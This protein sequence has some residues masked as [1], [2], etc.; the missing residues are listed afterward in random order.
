[1]RVRRTRRRCSRRTDERKDLCRHEQGAHHLKRRHR[2]ERQEAPWQH[3]PPRVH[4]RTAQ[5]AGAHIYNNVKAL[6]HVN[7]PG[8]ADA[9]ADDIARDAADLI[10][11]ARALASIVKGREVH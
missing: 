6:Y 2:A 5:G 7:D 11:L 9:L 8:A 10:A 4:L 1:M 3:I